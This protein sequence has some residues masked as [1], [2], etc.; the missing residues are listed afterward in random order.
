MLKKHV[1]PPCPIFP[2]CSLLSRCP[3][4]PINTSSCPY[5]D[6]CWAYLQFYES[7]IFYLRTRPYSLNHSHSN[8]RSES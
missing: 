5:E 3:P 7:L 6:C 4:V 1:P 8:D 2:H